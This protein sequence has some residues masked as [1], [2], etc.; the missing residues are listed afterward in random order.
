MIEMYLIIFM[1]R[2]SSEIKYKTKQNEVH[3]AAQKVAIYSKT[4]HF[5]CISIVC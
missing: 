2:Y 4:H 1:S 3:T 5:I